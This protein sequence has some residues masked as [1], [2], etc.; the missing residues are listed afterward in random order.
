M[1]AQRSVGIG[2][3]LEQLQPDFP[4]IS[5]SKIRY[6]E[7][8][9]LITPGRTPKGSRRFTDE[10]IERTRFV[11]TAQRDRFLPLKVIREHLD[12]LDRGLVTSDVDAVPVPPSPP[13]ARPTGLPETT[14]APRPALRLTAAEL[15]EAA[16]ISAA[17]LRELISFGLVSSEG[18][19]HDQTDLDVAVAAGR[20]VAHGVEV[21]HLRPFRSAAER[22]VALVEHAL[23]GEAEPPEG[24]GDPTRR[25]VA[26]C[27][28]LHT[29]L[30]RRGLGDSGR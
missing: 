5:I 1:A 4:D 14:L 19:H 8:Q 12:A 29:A 23:S 11:L 15:R 16:D 2:A 28:D 6:L 18:T 3:V 22:E 24:E 26:T 17:T 27:L 30:V 7:A 9:G 25:L 20:L 21:R 13:A 10:D